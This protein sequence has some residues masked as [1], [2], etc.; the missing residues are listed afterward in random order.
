MDVIV[1]WF[2][3]LLM[4][5]FQP[6]AIA[7]ILAALFAFSKKVE[8]IVP[9]IPVL[10]I[11]EIAEPIQKKKYKPR[12]PKEVKI[13]DDPEMEYPKT[14]DIQIEGLEPGEF[15]FNDPAL[16]ESKELTPEELNDSILE[17]ITPEIEQPIN[18]VA[19][20]KIEKKTRKRKVVERGL[21]EDLATHLSDSLS[22]KKD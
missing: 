3:L 12:K 19:E 1:N 8:D 9:T 14:F 6:L 17:E 7:L 20:P 18:T 21:P 11:P 16:E 5:V 22:K 10:P 13:V 2:L 15:S 4:I